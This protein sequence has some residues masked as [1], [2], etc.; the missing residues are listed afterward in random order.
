MFKFEILS[1]S[2]VYNN[3]AWSSSLLAYTHI[4]ACKSGIHIV[5]LGMPSVL[6]VTFVSVQTMKNEIVKHT[7]EV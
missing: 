7:D 6:S 1:Q 4:L 3:M 5:Y 2:P